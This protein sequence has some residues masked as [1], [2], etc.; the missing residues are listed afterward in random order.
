MLLNFEET[1]KPKIEVTIETKNWK[2]QKM[3]EKMEIT[4][5]EEITLMELRQSISETS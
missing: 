4:N 1:K 3:E 5:K 2:G